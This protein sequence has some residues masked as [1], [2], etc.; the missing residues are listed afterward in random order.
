MN[1]KMLVIVYVPFLDEEFDIFIPINKKVGTIKNIIISSIG[2]D[3]T[4]RVLI[5]EE[6]NKEIENN[7]YVKNS[8]I[9]NGSRLILV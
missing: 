8:S 2:I 4:N 7:V 6:D 1:N 5:N 3:N 9:K